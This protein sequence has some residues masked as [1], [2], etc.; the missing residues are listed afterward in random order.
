MRIQSKSWRPILREITEPVRPCISGQYFASA[1]PLTN[2]QLY[3]F[4]PKYREI[5]DSKQM[6]RMRRMKAESENKRRQQMI[7]WERSKRLADSSSGFRH[8]RDPRLQ[9]RVNVY[10]GRAPHDT[11]SNQRLPKQPYDHHVKQ[12]YH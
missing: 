12:P 6:T 8:S 2:K 11:Y 1:L 3:D 4:S 5:H 10:P 9:P 7:A